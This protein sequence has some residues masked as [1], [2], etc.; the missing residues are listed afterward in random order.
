MRPT[1]NIRQRVPL[2][3]IYLLRKSKNRPPLARDG[4]EGEL[5]EKY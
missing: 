3:E 4:K 5:L 1:L 2:L